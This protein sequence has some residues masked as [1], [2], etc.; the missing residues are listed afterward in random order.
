M[1]AHRATPFQLLTLALLVVVMI[2]ALVIYLALEQKRLG[3]DFSLSG[4]GGLQAIVARQTDRPAV[5]TELAAG[6]MRFEL[7][8]MDLLEEPDLLPRYPDYNR[9]MQRQAQIHALLQKPQVSIRFADGEHVVVAP[10]PSQ[11]SDLG[12]M[13]WLQ[14]FVASVASLFGA[15]VWVFRQHNSA[16][17][18]Y[19]LTGLFL[20]VV[21]F[22]AAIYSSRELALD[23]AIFRL[24]SVIDHLGLYLVMAAL[25]ALIWSYPRPLS[26]QPVAR[27]AYLAMALCWMADTAQLFPS[28]DV[29]TRLLPLIM[30]CFSVL[31]LVLHW[32]KSRGDA[33]YRQSIKWFLLVIVLGCGVFV[34][35]VFVPPLFGSSPLLAQ[36]LAFAAFLSIY[37]SLALG[38]VRLQ[39]F[40]LDRWWYEVWVWVSVGLLVAAVDLLFVYALNFSGIP[41][42]WGALA[43]AGWLYFPLRQ[44][45]MAYLLAGNRDAIESSLPQVV[46]VI[47]ASRS[48]TE[49]EQGCSECLQ[50]IYHPLVKRV[51]EIAVAQVLLDRQRLQMQLPLPGGQASL[52][53]ESPEQGARLFHQR[54]VQAVEAI[55]RLFELAVD[56][57]NARQQA[58]EQ[59][60][61][62]IKKDIHDSLGGR[63]LSIMHQQQEPTSASIASLAW[64]DLRDILVAFEGR[65][66]PFL[67]LSTQWQEEFRKQLSLHGI[68]LEWRCPNSEWFD[69]FEIS[70]RD[71]FELSQV[72]RESIAN[73]Q[74]HATATRLSVA[75]QLAGDQLTVTI[76]NN[77]VKV[78]P[79]RW[80]AGRGMAHIQQRAA[81]LGASVT[82]KGDGEDCVVMH[83]IWNPGH[84]QT[85][86][87][88]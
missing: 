10:R 1:L 47:A 78:E 68:E 64:R 60:R 19:F 67:Q 50:Q 86:T 22:P 65:S 35:T 18:H 52:V 11:I 37:L 84:D 8:A 79:E 45:L 26:R 20:G 66:T 55:L 87:G 83:L 38:V 57:M 28:L 43:V 29:S 44:R 34:F 49:L 32:G 53:L 36:G 73:A 21:I 59:E 51:S 33:L 12:A 13:F 46:R 82:W 54:D 62:R 7:E 72:L 25:I 80:E 14:L 75:F 16:T 3:V 70:G 61:R 2:N 77:G 76:E 48:I 30:L 85:S 15:S 31:L 63:L 39:L 88:G 24:L 69:L 9:F 41:A 23:G 17:L 56:A 27:M 6:G 40:E 58:T 4:D 71:R 42:L 74:R 81:N 5:V